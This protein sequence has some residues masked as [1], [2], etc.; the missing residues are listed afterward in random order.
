MNLELF[1][2]QSAC[3][4]YYRI[5]SFGAVFV[6]HADLHV[7]LDA[8]LGVLHIGIEGGAGREAYA[9]A[10][11]RLRGEGESRATPSAVTHDGDAG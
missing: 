1:S 7:W 11:G 3:R 5:Y 4:L 10:V 8:K 9:P 6:A 2:Q